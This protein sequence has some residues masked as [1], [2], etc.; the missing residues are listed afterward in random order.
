MVSSF[1]QC[2]GHVQFSYTNTQLKCVRDTKIFTINRL[3][4]GLISRNERVRIIRNRA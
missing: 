2:L 1:N 3:R 4:E